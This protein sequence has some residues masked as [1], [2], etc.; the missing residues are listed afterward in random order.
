MASSKKRPGSKGPT[1]GDGKH[2]HPQHR[3]CGT[4]R[5]HERLMREVPGYIEARSK[6]AEHAWRSALKSTTARSGC[7]RI[8]V[9]VHVVY[10]T[11]TENISD[12]QI[13]SQIAVLNQDFRKANPDVASVPVPFAALAADA[14]IQFELAKTDPSGAP[15]TGITRTST[16]VNGFVDDD[17]VKSSATGGADA[18]PADQYLN[19]WVCRLGGG[20]LGYAQFPGGP[21][22]TD[23]VVI[24]HTGF[25]TTGTAQA[26]FDLG[27]SATHEIGHWLDLYHIWGDDGSGCFGSDYVA[28]TPNQAGYNVGTPS[29]P[30]VS[31]S[32][33]PNGDMF[34]NFMDYV[35][36]EA[37]FM[38]T[39]GQVA[40]M[41]T[42]LDGPRFSI[43][44]T[45]PCISIGPKNPLGDPGKA[46][47]KEFIKEG[48][49]DLVKE[50]IKESPKELIK[51][52]PKEFIKDQPKELIK[53]LP[54]DSP[55]D[56]PYDHQ[57]A[58]AYDLM[59]K[60]LAPGPLLPGVGGQPLQPLVPQPMA[61]VQPGLPFVLGTGQE[62]AAG[63]A[64]APQAGAPLAATSPEIA[65]LQAGLQQLTQ[66]V[67][68]LL[69]LLQQRGGPGGCG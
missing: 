23:G 44:T 49:K 7:T 45:V 16:I 40:R 61:P 25:G 21:A 39:A 53:E 42:T 15:T 26:P 4:M 64:V 8:A 19:I 29:F 65:A 48:L 62:V 13:D 22:A 47:F 12:A 43:G 37:M 69:G 58:F 54:K 3:N 6:C 41:Q 46:L 5:N 56:L 51:E 17:K 24:T 28:D 1:P 11:A 68:G 27:R 60:G 31:C 20:L 2:E 57:K 35:D 33:G 30:K 32:N 38:F 50:P 59:P 9:V 14:R 36:D 63:P 52:T 55:K 18:W 10:R 67:Q 34:M 66:Q